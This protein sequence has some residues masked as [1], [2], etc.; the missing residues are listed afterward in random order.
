MLDSEKTAWFS[1]GNLESVFPSTVNREPGT[2]NHVKQ[3][4]YLVGH[5]ATTNPFLFVAPL[6]V[7]KNS[8][9]VLK[10]AQ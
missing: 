5:A 6:K 9:K 4:Q 1:V 8:S 7:F 2:L 3:S 10:N